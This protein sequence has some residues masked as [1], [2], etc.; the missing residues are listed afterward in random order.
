MKVP[1]NT[2]AGTAAGAK[3]KG[4][5]LALLGAR[6]EIYVRRGRRALLQ[7]MLDGNGTATADDVHAAID[8]PADLDPRWLGAIPGR[9]AYDGVIAAAGFVRSAR[10]ERHA[11]WPQ[12][13]RLL[14]RAAAER[15]LAAHPELPE[16]AADRGNDSQGVLFPAD[17]TNEPTPPDAAGR[18]G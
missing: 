13:W 16:P 18:V 7:A 2:A 10:A 12:V 11:C 3:L 6:R 8:V 17:L 15:W 5:A 1:R 9:L 14:D 4:D